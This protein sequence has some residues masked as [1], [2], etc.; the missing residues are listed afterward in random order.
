MAFGQDRFAEGREH[1]FGHARHAVAV[2]G[3]FHHDGELVAAQP[4]DGVGTADHAQ[5]ARGRCLE[6]AV[7]GGVA[8]RVVDDLEVVQVQ[9]QHRHAAALPPGAHHRTRQAL[10]QQAA[11]GQAGQ[12]VVV[13]QIA[14]LLLGALLVGDVVDHRDEVAAHAQLIA[15]FGLF[16]PAEELLAVGTPQPH[17]AAEVALG[18][19]AFVRQAVELGGMLSAFQQAVGHADDVLVAVAGDARERGIDRHEAEVEVDHG[20]R[21]VHAAQHFGSDAA[22][23]LGVAIGGDVVRGAGDAQRI[24]LGIAFH[25]LA[26]RTHPDPFVVGVADAVLGFERL[27]LAGQVVVHE[28]VHAR[29]IVG[30]DRVAAPLFR[31]HQLLVGNVQDL[32]GADAMDAV[33]AQIPVPVGIARAPERELEAVLALADLL[34]QVGLDGHA[35]P[36]VLPEQGTQA[37][38]QQATGRIGPARLPPRRQHGDRHVQLVRAPDAIAVG[39]ADA[40]A[41]VPGRQVGVGHHRARCGRTEF[42]VET[43]QLVGEQVGFRRGVVERGKADA[44]HLVL[45]RHRHGRRATEGTGQRVASDAV[46][47]HCDGRIKGAGSYLLRIEQVEAADAAEGDLSVAQRGHGAAVELQILQPRAQAEAHD[48][49]ILPVQAH[50]AVDSAQ[51]KVAMRVLCNGVDDRGGFSVR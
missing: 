10:G 19:Q 50:Q 1:R 40:E 8:E 46:P 16:H 41:V 11:V 45:L 39:G 47:G 13:G 32:V 9:E 30:M 49:S 6:D 3:V 22:F 48:A 36:L 35:A 51:P 21:L 23:A 42:G 15:Y 43:F 20:H 37:Q 27:G 34:E 5:Q 2:V 44:Q 18:V 25:H 4:S 28:L 24:E 38:R 26:A 12:G 17:L 7:T 14:Q 29:Q 33:G 31:T